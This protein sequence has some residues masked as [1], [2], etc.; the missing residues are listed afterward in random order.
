MKE[1]IVHICGYSKYRYCIY[2]SHSYCKKKHRWFPKEKLRNNKPVAP[3]E[4]DE[5]TQ[6]TAAYW[7]NCDLTGEQCISAKKN[8]CS[9][10]LTVTL[11]LPYISARHFQHTI[12]VCP[13]TS[14]SPF[15]LDISL[16]SSTFHLSSRWSSL[17]S[18][19]HMGKNKTST[20]WI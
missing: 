8:S 20:V 5:S 17:T 4:K 3:S 7:R 6:P 10:L 15:H 18:N 12:I 11:L 2:G 19:A 9:T 14:P 13:T 16:P 1:Q